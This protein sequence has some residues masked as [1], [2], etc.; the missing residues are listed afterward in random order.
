MTQTEDED[1]EL[2]TAR[3]SIIA[4]GPCGICGGPYAA[5]RMIDTQMGCVAAGDAPERVADDYDTT[6]E[7][8]VARWIAYVDLLANPPTV[9]ER[10]Q[11]CPADGKPC[12]LICVDDCFRSLE[13]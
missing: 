8:M 1:S 10:P 6:V 7:E 12:R 4:Q 9:D 5:H 2:A 11:T 13:P 3:A